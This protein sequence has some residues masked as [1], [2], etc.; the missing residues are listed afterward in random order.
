MKNFC[1]EQKIHFQ[2]ASQI[3]LLRVKQKKKGGG[4]YRIENEAARLI[5]TRTCNQSGL[6][7]LLIIFASQ[8]KEQKEF[9]PLRVD[10][11]YHGELQF[12]DLLR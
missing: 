11:R 2:K 5:C 9:F 1:T 10:S 7:Q 8:L 6:R 3:I 12:G 4:A